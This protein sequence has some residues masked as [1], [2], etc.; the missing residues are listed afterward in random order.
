MADLT[1]LPS[2]QRLMDLDAKAQ[3]YGK[4][5]VAKT[6]LFFTITLKDQSG[7][8]GAQVTGWKVHVSIAPSPG[9][10]QKAWDIFARLAA[11][12]NLRKFKIVNQANPGIGKQITI[13]CDGEKRD[14]LHKF[15]KALNESFTAII[16]PQEGESPD[17]KR[18]SSYI[19][20]RNE[21]FMPLGNSCIFGAPNGYISG[22]HIDIAKRILCTMQ[23]D[24][25]DFDSAYTAVTTEKVLKG[26]D[27]YQYFSICGKLTDDIPKLEVFKAKFRKEVNLIVQ[28]ARSFGANKIPWHN[29]GETEDF[30]GLEALRLP[31]VGVTVGEPAPPGS[32]PQRERRGAILLGQVDAEKLRR[33][34]LSSQEGGSTMPPALEAPPAADFSPKFQEDRREAPKVVEMVVG[35]PSSSSAPPSQKDPDKKPDDGCCGDKHCSLQ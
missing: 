10:I 2:Y 18:I 31:D 30:F 7:K 8:S 21:S 6:D 3:T 24:M 17:C 26:S 1:Q 15:L 29:L 13:Y 12:C 22:M 28:K 34:F 16:I 19:L 25:S 23:K 32:L 20:F 14:E 27:G 5:N 9:N 35:D 4:Y 11:D 33:N